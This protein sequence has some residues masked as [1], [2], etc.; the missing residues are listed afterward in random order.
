M[1]FRSGMRNYFTRDDIL[2]RA[3]I[4]NAQINPS[5]PAKVIPPLLPK[6]R[7]VH[8]Y[9]KVDIFIPGCPP[10]ADT[11]FQAV[12]ELLEGRIPEPDPRARFG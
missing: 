5:I 9:V 1:L 2:R 3:Y 11:I 10:Q 12:A 8:E 4:E 6:S 7:P